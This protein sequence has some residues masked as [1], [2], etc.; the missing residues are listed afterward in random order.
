MKVS[1]LHLSLTHCPIIILICGEKIFEDTSYNIQRKIFQ[2]IEGWKYFN[3]L[4]GENISIRHLLSTHCPASA[5]RVSSSAGHSFLWR[6]IL[7]GKLGDIFLLDQSFYR[8]QTK[9]SLK[10]QF[11]PKSTEVGQK[12][13]WRVQNWPNKNQTA[14]SYCR[15]PPNF[16]QQLL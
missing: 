1:G 10:R 3:I 12:L 8:P 13:S 14:N 7:K 9:R 16:T 2:Y 6:G 5:T 15:N 11:S 4:K